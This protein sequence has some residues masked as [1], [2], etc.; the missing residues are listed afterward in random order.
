[1]MFFSNIKIYV[2]IV[3]YIKY[4]MK[5]VMINEYVIMELKKDIG[6]KIIYK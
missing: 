5:L 3:N 6:V 1:M 2:Y 4:N